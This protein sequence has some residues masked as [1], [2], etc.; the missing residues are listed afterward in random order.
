MIEAR[1]KSSVQLSQGF[2]EYVDSGGQ[3]PPI[4]LVNAALA[5]D[6]LWSTVIDRLSPSYRCVAVVL[7]LGAH[8]LPMRADS[9]LSLRG[10]TRLL[11][12]FLEALDL[13]EVTLCFNDWSG[14]QIMVAAGWVDR[15]ARL[16]LISCETAGNYPPGLPGKFL[17]MLGRIPGGLWLGYQGMRIPAVHRLPFT[18]G[19]MTRTRFPRDLAA[20]W[21]QSGQR[22][23]AIRRDLRAYVSGVSSARSE[24]AAASEL[25]ST[26]ERP[27]LVVWG[28]EDRVMPLAEGR[29]LADGFPHASF[30][31]V[32]E[33]G[34]L[35]PLDQPERL[36]S[37]VDTFVRDD[38]P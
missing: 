36:A 11:A 18:F 17:A 24:L 3:G 25:L 26:F 14:A 15:V 31:T 2:I 13:R 28:A 22:D 37:L 5:D 32:E 23:R 10:Q 12:D 9:D 20:R 4:V 35:V 21:F 33:S 34:T 38:R 1:E 29:A 30:V 8:R 7:P 19:R 6:T 27:V 16:V